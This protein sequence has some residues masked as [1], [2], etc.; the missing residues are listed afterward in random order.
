M[1][2]LTQGLTLETLPKAFIHLANEV[3]EIKRLL[4]DRS[5]QPP[6]DPERWYN[7]N[8]LCEYLPDRPVAAT[9]YGWVHNAIIP[10]HKSGKKL[11][12]LKSEIDLWLKQGKKK[13]V[14]EIEAQAQNLNFLPLL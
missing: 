8:E 12:F 1:E 3:S 7:L 6:P 11:R 10:H 13:T 9:V 14:S 4:L 2:H 5:N